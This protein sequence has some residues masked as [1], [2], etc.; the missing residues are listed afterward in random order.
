MIH[1]FWI[2]M[3]YVLHSS[4]KKNSVFAWKIEAQSIFKHIE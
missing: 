1:D 3:G 2:I 4:E